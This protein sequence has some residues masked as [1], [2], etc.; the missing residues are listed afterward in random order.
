MRMVQAPA[1][2]PA[3]QTFKDGHFKQQRVDLD[4]DGGSRSRMAATVEERDF[5]KKRDG[6]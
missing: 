6:S 5:E 3:K 2:R 1:R 4:R